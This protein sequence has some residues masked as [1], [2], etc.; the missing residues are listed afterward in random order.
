M[1]Y[2][3]HA[4]PVIATDIA[5]NREVLG[6]INTNNLFTVGNVLDLTRLFVKFTDEKYRKEQGYKNYNL[7]LEM[8]N[9]DNFKREIFSV[10]K[11][12]GE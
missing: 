10:L 4:L 2:M 8:F 7:A 9:I 3:I 11:L 12:N 6:E 5:A 1:E